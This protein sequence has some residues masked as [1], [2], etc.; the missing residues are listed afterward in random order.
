MA[1]KNYGGRGIS[2]CDDWFLFTNFLRDMGEKP[3]GL[4][5]ERTDNNGD[6]C[7]SNCRWASVERQ[8]N[9][10]R[11]NRYITFN[12]ETL[13]VTQWSRKLGLIHQ[14]IFKRLKSG[15]TPEMALSARVLSAR[16]S[17]KI[18]LETRWGYETLKR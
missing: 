11:N 16:E 1:Y 7:P 10:K 14:T 6:Y 17:S 18:G 5:L 12:G 13:S 8:A 15:M 9:N 2:V 3:K 4:T